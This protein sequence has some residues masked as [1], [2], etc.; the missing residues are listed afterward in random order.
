[1]VSFHQNAADSIPLAEGSMDFG[2]CLGVLHHL[3]DTRAGL[4][5]CVSRLKPG[6]PF[7]LYVYY[8][9]DNRPLWFR[10]LWKM[11][12]IA[13]RIISRLPF[14]LKRALAALMAVLVYW[15]LARIASILA[16]QGKNV[17]DFPLSYYRSRS[18]YVMRTDALDR[19]G[20]RLEKRFSRKE[21]E[22]M[23]R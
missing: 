23:M 19:F 18:F 15:P 14:L 21:I 5:A 4:V 8:N 16:A 7:L 20:T 9:F 6:A 10:A 13:R 11:S 2:Y 1:N 3:P 12:D 17:D 22:A